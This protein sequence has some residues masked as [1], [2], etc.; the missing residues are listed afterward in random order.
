M[1]IV[2]LITAPEGNCGIIPGRNILKSEGFGDWL[3]EHVEALIKNLLKLSQKFGGKPF[4]YIADPSKMNPIIRKDTSA[5]FVQ[6]HVE[7]EK[8]GCRAIAF[9]MAL[10]HE[11]SVSEASESIRVS[12][13]AGIAF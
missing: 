2:D 4:A 8:A 3:P 12:G 5:A 13:N 6:L 1:N 10:P 11:A 9:W 7:L